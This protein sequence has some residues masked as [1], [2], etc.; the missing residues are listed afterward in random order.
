MA[1]QLRK[2]ATRVTRKN[3]CGKAE[4]ILLTAHDSAAAVLKAFDT[5]RSQRGRPSGMS[6]DQEQDLLRAMLVFAAAGLD[7]MV[8]QLIRDSL[9]A[10]IA[11][12]DKAQNAFVTFVDKQ[13]RQEGQG[14]ASS[15]RF[16]AR[17]LTRAEPQAALIEEYIRKLTD[18]SLQSSESLFQAVAALGLNPQIVGVIDSDLRPIFSVRNR[19]IHEL[20][21][22]LSVARRSRNVRRLGDM[23]AHTDCLLKVGEQILNSVDRVVATP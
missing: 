19:I 4:I 5:A 7:G 16:L 1:P 15:N 18:S 9:R 21:V 17:I 23:I 10:L 11:K 12:D 6:T 14:N 22:N 3:E 2:V 20:D 8:K 13:L